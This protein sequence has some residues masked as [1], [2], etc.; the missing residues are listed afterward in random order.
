MKHFFKVFFIAL[1]CFG[2]MIGAGVYSYLKFFEPEEI[3][4]YTGEEDLDPDNDEEEVVTP[5]TRTPLEKA[6]NNSK[7]INILLLGLEDARSDTIMVISF[8]KRTSEANIISIPRDTYF[9]RKGYDSSGDKKF[10]AIF[11]ASGPRGVMAA[12]EFILGIPIDKY[13]TVDYDAVKE[14]VDVIGGVE[15]N[16][17]FHMYY[18]D[19]YDDPPLVIDIPAGKQIL[20]GEKA[21]EYLRFR[22]NNDL[23]VGYPDGDIGRI[24]AQQ[25]FIKLA[26]KKSL[27]F[28]LPIVVKEVYRYVK[29]DFSLA[30]VLLLVG[31]ALNFSTENMTMEILPGRADYIEDISYYIHDPEQVRELVYKLYDV[32]TE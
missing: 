16:V 17:P 9:H 26:I 8:D 18:E 25:D 7:R 10:N 1:L 19:P 32:E 12:A 21:L 27:S 2:L 6:I 3:T 29:T 4:N 13:I 31:D 28:Q 5:D 15:V 14:A 24:N 20:D 30:D 22:H 11:S 23:T